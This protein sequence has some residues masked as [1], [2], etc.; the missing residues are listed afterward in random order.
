MEKV[1]IEKSY[2]ADKV[3]RYYLTHPSAE[4]SIILTQQELEGLYLQLFNIVLKPKEKLEPQL[5]VHETDC[6][7]CGNVI[8][9]NEVRSYTYDDGCF[10]DA[11]ATIEELIK[12]GFIDGNRVTVIEGDEIYQHLNIK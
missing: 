4:D 12:I 5:I 9:G 8:Y 10:G 2:G 3:T 7:G 1:N 11:R 6:H